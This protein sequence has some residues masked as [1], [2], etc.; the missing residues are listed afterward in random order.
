MSP[1]DDP[2]IA[3][4]GDA[5][6]AAAPQKVGGLFLTLFGMAGTA[7]AFCFASDWD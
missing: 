5:P 6:E 3:V 7:A 1:T 2:T 4:D